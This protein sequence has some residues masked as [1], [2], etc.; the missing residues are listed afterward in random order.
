MPISNGVRKLA[1]LFLRDYS[2]YHIYG[3][4]C[5]GERGATDIGL[6]FEAVEEK[7]IMESEDEMIVEQ[8]WY[9]G[10]YAKAYACM[11][12]SRIVG[13]CFFWYG[14]RY[15]TRNFWPLKEDEAKLVQL[16][17]LPS[18][19]GKGIATRLVEFATYDM[20]QLGFRY[21]YAR[22]WWSNWPSLQAFERAG[23]RYIT[24]VID[25]FLPYRK[26]PLRLKLTK[27]SSDIV[28]CKSR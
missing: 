14:K 11:S 18:M 23:W 25:L 5:V 4:E 10:N 20:A 3:R 17:V 6:R 24:T 16:I 19:R 27:K 8:A 13:L 15:S 2:I 7:V 28:R 12:D 1:Q 9:C 22:I 26:K 21:V